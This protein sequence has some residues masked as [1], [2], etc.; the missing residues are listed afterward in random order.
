MLSPFW[1]FQLK[2]GSRFFFFFFLRPPSSVS[3]YSVEVHGVLDLA[4]GHNF[5]A[6][7]FG[8]QVGENFRFESPQEER[9]HDP[10]GVLDS[11]LFVGRSWPIFRFLPRKQFCMLILHLVLWTDTNFRKNTHREHWKHFL[12]LVFFVRKHFWHDTEITE[13]Y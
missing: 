8:R 6:S 2:F 9:F 3:C 12:Q 1:P 11:V 10:L 5:N 7:S 13:N 4:H